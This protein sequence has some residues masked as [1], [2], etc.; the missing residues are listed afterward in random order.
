MS[1]P[2]RLL[3][4]GAWYHVMNRGAGRRAIFKGDTDRERFLA[5]LG[6]LNERYRIE[7]HAYC[8]MGNHYHVLLHTPEA[9]LVRGM[10]HLNGVYTQRFNHAH[11]SDGALFRGR[12]RAIVVDQD[13]YALQV[14]RYIHRNPVEARLV[15]NP[16][17]YRWSSLSAYLGRRTPPAWLYTHT[18]LGMLGGKS[19][20]AA[21][22]AYVY[23]GLDEPTR[24]F[25]AK[26]RTAPVLG[27]KTFV[28]RMARRLP[29]HADP[30]IPA[31]ERH[32]RRP[33]LGRILTQVAAAYGTSVKD[34]TTSR[35]GRASHHVARAAAMALARSAGGCDLATLAKTFQVSHYST[36]SV[37][38]S[39]LRTRQRTDAKL[40][41]RLAQLARQLNR[42]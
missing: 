7:C 6:E 13:N 35:R 23:A 29:A 16:A 21:Y 2:L 41:A 37:A 34:L 39:R 9:N 10:R 31:R 15:S 28:A 22:R 38:V 32:L 17:R 20:R 5:L 36:V 12:Y 26:T 1:R 11:R 3:F 24:A 42:G 4:P 8:L 33:S 40:A 27:E 14:S 25:Y 19:P 30:E 18:I